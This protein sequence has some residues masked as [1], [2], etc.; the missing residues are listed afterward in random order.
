ME[1]SLALQ[2]LQFDSSPKTVEGRSA[3]EQTREQ[4]HLLAIAHFSQVAPRVKKSAATE[5][6]LR[7][8]DN[9]GRNARPL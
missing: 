2:S 5:S 6:R 9:G 3:I 1:Q 7:I 8:R 4:F